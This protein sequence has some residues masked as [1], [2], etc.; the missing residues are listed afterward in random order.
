[1]VTRHGLRYCVLVGVVLLLSQRMMHA[2]DEGDSATLTVLPKDAI[3][4]V[5]HSTFVPAQQAQVLKSDG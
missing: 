3:P 1:M 2:A 5:R 4:A